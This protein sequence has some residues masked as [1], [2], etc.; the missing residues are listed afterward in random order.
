MKRKKLAS[1]L[2]TMIA[3]DVDIKMYSE[4]FDRFIEFKEKLEIIK[5]KIL[6]KE[7]LDDIN[8]YINENIE[9]INEYIIDSVKELKNLEFKNNMNYSDIKLSIND[10]LYD[11]TD[12][13]HHI[14]SLENLLNEDDDLEMNK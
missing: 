10:P 12:Y 13:Y 9:N 11:N 3:N 4:R 7:N 1:V 2:G 6:N 8:R 14:R 5:D